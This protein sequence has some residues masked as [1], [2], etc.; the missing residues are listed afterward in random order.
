MI[1]SEYFERVYVISLPWH[2][3]RRERL[4]A[5]LKGLV[6]ARDLEFMEAIAGDQ[7][8]PPAW[9]KQGGG[10]WGCLQSHV[11]VLQTIWQ[12]GH[13]R[14]LVVEDDAVVD[15]DAKRQ[16]GEL[17]SAVP[18]D[19]GQ[20]YLGGQHQWEPEAKGRVFIGKSVNRTHCYGVA[21]K[22]VPGILQHIQHAPDY[23]ENPYRHVDHQLEVAHQR[24]DWPVYC[25]QW[26]IFGQGENDSAINGHHHPDKW[27]DWAGD[28]LLKRL[29]WAVLAANTP[30][31]VIERYRDSIHFGWS[32]GPDGKTDKGIQSGVALR[33]RTSLER[34][35]GAIRSEAWSMRRIPA[36]MVKNR[37]QREV[38]LKAL[39]CETI[40]LEE[41][42]NFNH[43]EWAEEQV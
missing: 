24:G 6:R 8:Y 12:R 31:R 41:T 19:W 3:E 1:L 29:P 25:P 23:I 38:I 4:K 35:I 18:G 7:L 21:R 13:E 11:R 10:A 14:A 30:N 34:A 17:F 22:Y 15:A 39:G 43:R 2:G 42:E 28:G 26:W 16:L 40:G 33:T 5:Q 37:V 27:W 36:V 20:L 9:W 32:V